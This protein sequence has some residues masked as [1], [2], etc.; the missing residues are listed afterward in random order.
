MKKKLVCLL[1]LGVFFSINVFA[2]SELTANSRQFITY[3]TGSRPTI[4]LT[5]D[6]GSNTPSRHLYI[7]NGD[8]DSVIVALSSPT[9]KSCA[10]FAGGAAT[11]STA[12]EGCVVLNGNST[13]ELV[14]YRTDGISII[15]NA[16]EAS[17]V[18]V[19][20]NW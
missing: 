18:S 1:V 9:V 13:L 20:A 8:S 11:T 7:I 6:S 19:I 14:N 3:V 10:G 15:L 17:P 16:A 2:A 5:F 12:A 4:G